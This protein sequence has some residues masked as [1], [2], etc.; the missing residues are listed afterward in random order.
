[1]KKNNLFKKIML[2]VSYLFIFLFAFNIVIAAP[3]E[4]GSAGADYLDTIG[5]YGFDRSVSGAPDTTVYDVVIIII[6]AILSLLGVIFIALI[7]YGGYTWMFAGGNENSVTN[8]KKILTNSTIGVAVVLS[9]AAISQFVIKGIQEGD[10]S[11]WATSDVSV[12][13]IIIRI[14]NVALSF[15]GVFFVIVIIYS[16]YTWMFS[17]GNDDKIQAAK[18]RLINAVIGAVVVLLSFAI[19]FFV[20][21]NVG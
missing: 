8:A 19:T 9:A 18:K 5:E 1:M 2:S 6:N 10:A 20:F 14:I 15:F 21:S 11:T 12:M 4:T 16:G 13:D 17:G 7:I 3:Y